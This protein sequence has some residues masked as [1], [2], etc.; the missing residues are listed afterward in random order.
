MIF[1]AGGTFGSTGWSG[2]PGS[3]STI[4]CAGGTFCFGLT[5]RWIAEAGFV[6]PKVIWQ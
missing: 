6:V 5:G 1:C 2:L 3:F 4:F